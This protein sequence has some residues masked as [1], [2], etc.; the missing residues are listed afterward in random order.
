M[1]E[2]ATNKRRIAQVVKKLKV[3]EE[4]Q[5]DLA[6]WLSRSTEERFKVFLSM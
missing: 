4:D 2:V 1:N 5:A 3:G 6:H